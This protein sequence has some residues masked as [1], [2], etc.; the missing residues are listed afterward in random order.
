MIKPLVEKEVKDLLRDPRIIVP[1]ILGALLLPLLGFVIS[2]SMRAAVEQAVTGTQV[3]GLL[4]LDGTPTSAEL[5]TWLE[6][7][8]VSVVR[9]AEGSLDSLAE[10]AAGRGAEVVVIIPRGFGEAISQRRPVNLTFLN[11]V[12]ELS[13]LGVSK[14]VVSA[15]LIEEYVSAAMLRGTGISPSVVRNP[16]RV[17]QYTFLTSKGVQLPG[18]PESLV[19][20]SLSVMLI[21]LIVVM[22]ALTTMQMSATSMAVENEERTLETLLTLPVPATHILLAKLLAMFVVA[23]LGSVLQLAG[24]VAYFLILMSQLVQMSPGQQAPATGVSDLLAPGASTFLAAPAQLVSPQGLGA[25][26]VSLLLSLFFCAALGVVV[27]A[28]SKDVRIA[29]TMVSPLATLFI[30]PIFLIVYMSSKAMNPLLRAALY[31]LPFTQ[32]AILSKEMIAYTLP[33]EL[34]VYLTASLALTLLM[35]YLTSRLLS[36]ETLSRLQR[37]IS[38]IAPSLKRK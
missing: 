23:L 12:E 31:I 30:V 25:L 36:I 18:D 4:D 24:M 7:R 22:L 9:L 6:Q 10:E 33:P 16:V 17:A 5:A 20:L 3:I 38:T 8:G 2:I 15:S 21:P 1:F 11:V 28:L 14:A 32:P 37:S 29:S 27:G 19:G 13:L 35:V 34:P 26:A